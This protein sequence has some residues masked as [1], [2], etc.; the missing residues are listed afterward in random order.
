M[1]RLRP[2]RHPGVCHSGGLESDGFK[3]GLRRSRRVGG[4]SWPR[5]GKK[6]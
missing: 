1:D 2:E 4:G 3:C 6:R 5:G